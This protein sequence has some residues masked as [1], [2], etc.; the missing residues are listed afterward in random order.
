M[1]KIFLGLS[2]VLFAV[3]SVIG[4]DGRSETLRITRSKSADNVRSIESSKET[5]QRQRSNSAPVTARETLKVISRWAH[6]V[7]DGETKKR[8]DALIPTALSDGQHMNEL[9]SLVC[10][11]ENTE[12]ASYASLSFVDF[13]EK[14][15]SD[16]SCKYGGML[17]HIRSR[18]MASGGKAVEPSLF[19]HY[20]DSGYYNPEELSE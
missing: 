17:D 10:T 6:L 12:Y 4:M 15:E 11:S 5:L 20:Y 19:L 14:D 1:R 3:G 13:F 18:R 8:I 7:P 9:I 2:S 16:E